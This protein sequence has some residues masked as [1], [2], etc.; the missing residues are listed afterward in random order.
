MLQIRYAHPMPAD[1]HAAFQTTRWSLVLAARDPRP[2]L[3][4]LA[5]IAR[6]LG[7]KALTRHG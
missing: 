6:K 2:G 1:S 5:R 3:A 4:D 7:S